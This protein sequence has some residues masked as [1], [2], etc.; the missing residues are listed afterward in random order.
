MFASMSVEAPLL[1]VGSASS[2]SS[3]EP[4]WFG[5]VPLAPVED[6]EGGTG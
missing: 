4:L 6:V 1:V 2:M 5:A 3:E